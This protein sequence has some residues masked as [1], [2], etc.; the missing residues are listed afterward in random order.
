MFFTDLIGIHVWRQTQTQ[1]VVETL[2]AGDGDLF[3]PHVFQIN[4][5]GS[6]VLRMEF[7][8]MQGLFASGRKLFGDSLFVMRFQ[9]FLLSLF[10]LWGFSRLAARVF[11]NFHWA[12]MLGA[13][14]LAFSPLFY[15]YA[16]NPLPDNF[17]LC[18]AV[19]SLSFLMHFLGEK[20][21]IY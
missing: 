2:A 12:G 20:K 8:L 5:K 10:T 13:W 7:P 18:T 11:P 16:I 21:A 19:W 9:C 4:D 3:S 1:T 6:R 14:C 17:A 15:Y